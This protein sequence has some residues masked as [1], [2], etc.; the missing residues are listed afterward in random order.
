V[1]RQTRKRKPGAPIG[2]PKKGTAAYA[3][4]HPTVFR[5]EQ[6]P[7][8]DRWCAP[9]DERAEKEKRAREHRGIASDDPACPWDQTNPMIKSMRRGRGRP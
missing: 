8:E 3:E 1:S 5:P 6:P 7:T 9:L 4:L 2:P